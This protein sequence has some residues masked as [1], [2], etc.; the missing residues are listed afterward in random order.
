MIAHIERT[1]PQIIGLSL[2]TKQRLPA[3]IRLVVAIR[4]VIPEAII[5]V[6]PSTSVDAKRLRELVD[7]D[8]VFADVSSAFRELDLLMRLRIDQ[9]GGHVER[10]PCAN[11]RAVI[12]VVAC[13][14]I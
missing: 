12:A 2:S 13:S 5:G 14:R 9:M 11:T 8:L 10:A 7:I 1:Q 3:L 4:L 6:A